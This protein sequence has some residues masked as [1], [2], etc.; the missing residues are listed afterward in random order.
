VT[1]HGSGASCVTAWF[2]LLPVAMLLKEGYSWIC[3][4]LNDWQGIAITVE[5]PC[6]GA[7]PVAGSIAMMEKERGTAIDGACLDALKR[8]LPELG[9]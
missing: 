1:K 4:G 2:L 7:I 9:F 6:R 5:R 8:S 3:I